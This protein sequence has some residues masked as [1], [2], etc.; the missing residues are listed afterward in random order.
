MK[1]ILIALCVISITACERTPGSQTSYK[2]IMIKS[3]GEVETLPN[4]ASFRIELYCLDQSVKASKACLVK[5]SNELMVALEAFGI[6]KND[7]RTTSVDLN[8]S[9]TWRNN[10][11]VF[12]GYRSS[13][14]L[15][16]TVKNIDSIDEVYTELLEN[17]NLELSGLAYNHSKLDSLENEAY[18][19]ALK[20]AGALADK[21]LQN[22]PENQK[23]VLKIGNVEITSSLPEAKRHIGNDAAHQQAASVAPQSVG[24]NSG[25][26]KVSATLFVEYL[27]K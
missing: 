1:N 20:K 10:S 16:V 19:G 15:I 21:L 13:T 7:I 25:M 14:A 12:E 5:K 26:M 24:M 22:L 17:R 6:S 11:N 2:S 3:I 9:Y 23:E 18:M 8:K 4:E 27:I